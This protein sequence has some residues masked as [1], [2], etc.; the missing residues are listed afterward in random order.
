MTANLQNMEIIWCSFLSINKKEREAEIDP[1]MHIKESYLKKK[2]RCARKRALIETL[3]KILL[4]KSQKITVWS[5][6]FKTI[7]TYLLSTIT[8]M[9][10]I[11]AFVLRQWSP[12]CLTLMIPL[13]AKISTKQIAA[14][15]HKNWTMIW[16]LWGSKLNPEKGSGNQT[17]E[18][19]FWKKLI[20]MVSLWLPLSKNRSRK[21]K[22]LKDW[23]L[24]NN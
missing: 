16:L 5:M 13:L 21:I 8:L 3:G 9:D 20:K 18:H 7:L 14:S 11:S 22:K 12:P 1:L 4:K 24:K 10:K 6:S 2:A 17:T 23:P 19:T 15:T